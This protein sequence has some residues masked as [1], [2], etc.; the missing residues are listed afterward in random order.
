MV[1]GKLKGQQVGRVVTMFM[2]YVYTTLA[3]RGL[4]NAMQ[5]IHML[6]GKHSFSSTIFS[7]LFL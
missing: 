4:K 1:F 2:K 7:K 5:M 6:E 3:L